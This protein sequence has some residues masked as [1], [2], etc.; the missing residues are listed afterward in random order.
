MTLFGL[1][2]CGATDEEAATEELGEASVRSVVGVMIAELEIAAELEVT[3]ELEA[4]TELE[5]AAELLATGVVEAIK[6]ASRDEL[7]T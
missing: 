5:R 6:A 3:A 4:T 1:K 7:A 2:H